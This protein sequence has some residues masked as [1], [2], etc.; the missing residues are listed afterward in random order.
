M[1]ENDKNVRLEAAETLDGKDGEIF[2]WEL[3]G[4]W[5]LWEWLQY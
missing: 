1:A 2:G 3:W 5:E 4:I